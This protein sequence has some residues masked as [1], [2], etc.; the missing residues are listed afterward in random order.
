MHI[1]PTIL[2]FALGR[3]ITGSLRHAD[4]YP[5]TVLR[6]L[7]RRTGLRQRDLE[8][9][10]AQF[11]ENGWLRRYEPAGGRR[12]RLTLAGS[13][14]LHQPVPPLWRDWRRHW[15][16]YRVRRRSRDSI[17]IGRQQTPTRRRQDRDQGQKR[18]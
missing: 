10:L 8:T 5:I 11:C 9:V 4:D 7:W 17:G 13:V 15:V 16:L 2:Q 18:G 14:E 6:S 1:T 12:Y 3:L